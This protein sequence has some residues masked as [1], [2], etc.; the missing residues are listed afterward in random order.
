MGA[1]SR[2]RDYLMKKYG[3]S[4]AQAA[5]IDIDMEKRAAADGLEYHLTEEGL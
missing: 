1:T 4:S 5:Q 3:W 2:R